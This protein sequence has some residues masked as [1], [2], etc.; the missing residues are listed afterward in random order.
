[1]KPIKHNSEDVEVEI[2]AGMQSFSRD[3]ELPLKFFHFLGRIG[4]AWV[5]PK[6]EVSF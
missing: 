6:G 3:R 2:V 1:M 4:S 5:I